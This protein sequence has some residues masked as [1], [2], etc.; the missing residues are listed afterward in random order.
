MEGAHLDFLSTEGVS[1]QDQIAIPVNIES[2]K[3]LGEK[4]IRGLIYLNSGQYIENP[5]Y[6]E[7]YTL[8]AEKSTKIREIL[9]VY[10]KVFAREPGIS[11]KIATTAVDGLSSLFEIEIWIRL[12]IYG[13]VLDNRV[14][15]R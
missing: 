11:V 1:I 7:T 8:Y 2:I 14:A 3:M 15:P 12:K 13:T 6:V 5:F 9:D 10:G 4:I